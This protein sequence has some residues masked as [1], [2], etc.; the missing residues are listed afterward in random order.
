[1]KDMKKQDFEITK[2]IKSKI[3][4]ELHIGNELDFIFDYYNR[5]VRKHKIKNT[6]RCHR[7]DVGFL[8]VCNIF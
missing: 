5:K 6:S 3:K 8:I 2:E 1:M 4:K 7:N